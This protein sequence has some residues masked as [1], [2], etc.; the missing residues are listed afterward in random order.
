MFK[1]MNVSVCLF[2]VRGSD[3]FRDGIDQIV[4]TTEIESC[5]LQEEQ[6]L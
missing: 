2:I 6:M 4:G 5:S 3:C 1:W